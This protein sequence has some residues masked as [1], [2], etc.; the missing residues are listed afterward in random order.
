MPPRG[1]PKEQPSPLLATALPIAPT[2]TAALDD[3]ILFVD[4]DPRLLDGVRR[5]LRGKFAIETAVGPERGL[6]L[7][8]QRPPYAV[9]VADMNMPGMDGARFLGC[10]REHSPDTVRMML[11]GNTDIDTAIAAVNAGN[12][13][14]FI[15]K[16]AT[17]E[18]LE[19]FLNAG[20][21][22]RRLVAAMRRTAAA[23]EASRA[24]SDFL[25]TVSHEM[26][27]PLTVI[28]SAVELLEHFSDDEPPA[29]RAEFVATI[30]AH[31]RRLDGMIDQLLLLAHLDVSMDR[32][33]AT[34]TFDLVAVL[35]SAIAKV[36]LHDR[37]TGAS[38]VLAGDPGTLRCR[39]QADLVERAF[40]HVLDNA[41]RFSPPS[42]PV[43][44]EVVLTGAHARVDVVDRG[45]GIPAA[46]ADRVFEPFV[47]CSDV[48]VGKPPGLG[49]GLTIVRRV[50]H[51]HGGSVSFAAEADGGTRF[52]LTLPLVATEAGGA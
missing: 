13:F 2:I 23:E 52:S 17:P 21:E 1:Q 10:V 45:S 3:P 27:T 48:L 38:A 28:R 50:M 43:R 8:A 47:Q 16:P 4:D 14:R 24:K 6:E 25:A 19:Q 20:L 15:S 30:S 26:R 46:I 35:R 12:V 22:Q 37:A 18:A 36:P 42:A 49:L 34:D 29:V 39:G 5:R 33:L 9:V 32:P 41:Y 31:A 40:S 44:V 51:H 7:L 11:T